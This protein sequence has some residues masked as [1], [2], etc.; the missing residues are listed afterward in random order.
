MGKQIY[1]KIPTH[2]LSDYDLFPMRLVDGEVVLC[3]KNP[4]CFGKEVYKLAAV[5]EDGLLTRSEIEEAVERLKKGGNGH[6]STKEA[7]TQ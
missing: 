3:T 2:W 1:V 5:P 4:A 7:T 6:E